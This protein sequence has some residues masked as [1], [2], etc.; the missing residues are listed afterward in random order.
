MILQHMYYVRG[1]P[2]DL[3]FALGYFVT[4]NIYSF[5]IMSLFWEATSIS[6]YT[7]NLPVITAVPGGASQNRTFNRMHSD[8]SKNPDAMQMLFAKL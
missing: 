7:Y 6:E 3:K 4:R 2:S 1:L 5:Q 8:L